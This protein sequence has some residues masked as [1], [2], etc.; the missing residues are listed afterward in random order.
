MLVNK[1]TVS[2]RRTARSAISAS[3]ST[4]TPS[5]ISTLA[6]PPPDESE[7]TYM[8]LNE[9]ERVD[10][11]FMNKM[12]ERDLKQ[13]DYNLIAERKLRS[14]IQQSISKNYLFITYQC[15][16][17]LD[18]MLA[19]KE[20]FK[21]TT[22]ATKRQI[23]TD[24]NT[25]L[26]PQRKDAD[27]A[28]WLVKVEVKYREAQNY[29]VPE[30]TPDSSVL[31]FLDILHSVSPEFATQWD[32]RIAGGESIDFIRLHQ[33][34]RDYLRNTATR[35]TKSHSRTSAFGATLQGLDKYGNSA[36]PKCL[37]G[38]NHWYR[39]CYY[40]NA[41]KRPKEWK[42]DATLR[43]QIDD[44]LRS[45]TTLRDR[46]KRSVDS[47]N[48]KSK[49]VAEQPVNNSS[50]SSSVA[51]DKVAPSNIS[52]SYMVHTLS[53]TTASISTASIEQYSY[54]LKESF[55]LDSGSD[56]HVCNDKSRMHN[57]RTT[58]NSFCRAGNSFIDIEGWGSVTLMT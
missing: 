42:P 15:D 24:W 57:F 12:Y 44:K 39:E 47:A 21:P 32:V 36:P 20:Q 11:Q 52:S 14:V 7:A 17:A 30:I 8:D 28:K 51:T 1:A 33:Q 4:S 50:V 19:A 18:M 56:G 58:Y 22:L 3:S 41:E 2:Q 48:S 49:R 25:L 55:I 37:C 6:S 26:S 34:F 5:T 45:D 27:I 40:L 35:S 54:E 43:K 23:N 13:F 53:N 29:A 31:R 10:F 46:I 16:S 9:A 38:K